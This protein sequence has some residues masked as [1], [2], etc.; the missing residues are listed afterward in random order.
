M[1]EKAF[2]HVLRVFEFLCDV[3]QLQAG[4][5]GA[6]GLIFGQPGAKEIALHAASLYHADVLSNII[7]SG[8]VGGT[9]KLPL[10]FET[11]AEFYEDALLQEGVP[12]NAIILE[13]AARNTLENVTFGMKEARK[14]GIKPK[15]MVA[16]GIPAHLLRCVLTLRRQ[17]SGILIYGS[18]HAFDA[19][20]LCP[21]R[22]QALRILGEFQRVVSY[23][24]WGDI[25][26]IGIPKDILH[27]F[28]LACNAY[29]LNPKE[30]IRW[31]DLEF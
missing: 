28:I 22:N 2:L 29:G 25:A 20:A 23:M 13:P 5:R 8:G 9:G 12:L 3:P 1:V 15:M 14:R 16:V 24:L 7:V 10:G 11:E 19:K 26:A 6:T 31:N 21:D 18:T 17:T 4:T 30:S 27:A